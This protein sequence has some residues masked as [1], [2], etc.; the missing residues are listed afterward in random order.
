MLK[1]TCPQAYI[2]LCV[3]DGFTLESRKRALKEIKKNI[4][5]L[6]KS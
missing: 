3:W 5:L 6:N 4:I 1:L 2:L